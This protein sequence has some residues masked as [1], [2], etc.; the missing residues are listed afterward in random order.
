MN[1]AFAEV[2]A[3]T[4][5]TTS[6]CCVEVAGL[7]HFRKGQVHLVRERREVGSEI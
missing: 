4:F 1:L 6:I 5:F 7:E 2:L 3:L